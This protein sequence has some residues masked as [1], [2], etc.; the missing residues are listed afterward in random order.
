MA[1]V[2]HMTTKKMLM[3][4]TREVPAAVSLTRNAR[5]KEAVGCVRAA[6]I[7]EDGQRQQTIARLLGCAMQRIQDE[8]T[9]KETDADWEFNSLALIEHVLVTEEHGRYKTLLQN[10]ARCEQLRWVA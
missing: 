1:N 7:A 2:Y 5:G 9:R 8:V 6:S 4:I 10:I 3:G